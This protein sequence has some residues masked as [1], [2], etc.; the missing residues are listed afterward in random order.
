MGNRTFGEI[1]RALRI[2]ENE[3]QPMLAD[4]LGISRSAVSMYE[5]GAREPNFEILEAIA[6]HYNVDMDYLLGRTDDPINYDDGDLIASIPLSY[7]EACNGDVRRAY[8]AMRAAEDDGR[9]EYRGATEPKLD[10]F[11]FAM[12]NA[13]RDLTEQDK[14]LL[15]DMA[16]RLRKMNQK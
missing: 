8:A 6:D 16:A 1:L 14:Q 9:T 4:I 2:Q 15:I 11:T 3:T 10:D 12:H 7:M 13:S 5:S